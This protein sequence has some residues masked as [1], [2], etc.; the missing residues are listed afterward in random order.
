MLFGYPS[1]ANEENWL[2]DCMVASVTLVHDL[3]EAQRPLPDWPEI[4]PEAYRAKL[5]SR[6][7]LRDCFIEYAAA[8]NQ[9]DAEERNVVLDALLAHNKISELLGGQCDCLGIAD[10][11]AGIREPAKA[12][13]TFAFKLLTE[14]G[15]RQRQYEKVCSGIPERI[16][17]FCGCEGLEAPGLPQEDLDH[18]LPRSTYP[19]AAANLRNLAPMGGRCNSSYKRTQDPLRSGD[20]V[21]RTAFN[22]YSIVGVTISLENSV[23][24]EL[25]PGPVISD[26]V[27]DFSQDT[28]EVRTWDEVF[29]VRERWRKNFLDERTFKKWLDGFRSFCKRA[30]VQVVDDAQLVKAIK[31]Y[32]EHLSDCGFEGHAFLKAATFQLIFRKCEAGS[33]RLLP[34]FRDLVGV[35]Q[36]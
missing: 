34:I 29:R 15:I 20:G 6:H 27:I 19:F 23:V 7:G 22:P 8:A 33:G 4:I 24:D 16:C 5:L 32:Q 36:P 25:T 13:F 9:L 21:R 3:I 18:Y 11:P 1:A 10:L 17:P 14:F 30:Q 31:S 26:W 2:N 12:L 28:E 35:P